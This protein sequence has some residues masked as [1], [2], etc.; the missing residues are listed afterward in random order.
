MDMIQVFHMNKGEGETSYAKNSTNKVLSIT[1][2]FLEAAIEDYLTKF[3]YFP[4]T[5]AIAELGCSSGPNA[6][7]AVSEI[8]DA[9]AEKC[10]EFGR[11]KSPELMVFL[12]D[13]PGNDFNEVFASLASFHAKLKD[14]K[15]ADFGPCFI[16]GLPGSFHGRIVPNNC[17][18]IVHSSSSLHWLSQVPT[19]LD[20]KEH[21]EMVNKGK[22]YLSKT[23][24]KSVISA[25]ML[26]FRKDFMSFLKCRSE[27]VIPGGR[28]V[29]AFTGRSSTDPICEIACAF[30]DLIAST[31]MTMVSEGILDEERVDSFNVPY[32]A[33]CLEELKQMIGEEASFSLDRFEAFEVEWDGGEKMESLEETRGERIAKM[34]RAVLEP[35]FD[36]HFG[37]AVVYELFIRYA[38]IIDHFLSK[39]ALKSI[40]LII[41]LTRN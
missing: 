2:S 24:P 26:Q 17:L 4:E 15:G 38:R 3:G 21:G 25:Y 22:I 6:L 11:R 13:L 1:K 16:A 40:Y 35:M 34:H 36:H 20:G 41:S 5:M 28:M 27:E 10:L 9:V 8:L 14:E 39:Q 32:Y 7:M 18:H 29:L 19:G 37:R 31:L 12:N 30:S 23:S 33:P